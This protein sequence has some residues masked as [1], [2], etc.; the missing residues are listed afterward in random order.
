VSLNEAPFSRTALCACA[1]RCEARKRA[2]YRGAASYATRRQGADA[3]A[4][5]GHPWP[6]GGRLFR[7]HP[8]CAAGNA[9][10]AAAWAD[11]CLDGHPGLSGPQLGCG[12]CLPLRPT[13]CSC[14]SGSARV[15][16]AAACRAAARSETVRAHACTPV[17]VPRVAPPT[18]VVCIGT[19]R[20][21][22]GRTNRDRRAD[23]AHPW[24]AHTRH[25]RQ[26]EAC[27][28]TRAPARVRA[29][30]GRTPP[31]QPGGSTRNVNERAVSAPVVR[32]PTLR[33]IGLSRI[34]PGGPRHALSAP[35]GNG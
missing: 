15:R 27:R 19:V 29:G 26:R 11:P 24:C 33:K 35:A 10:L 6:L 16:P 9:A 25:S 2:A 3:V 1:G 21:P 18:R 23:R 30:G 5:G 17:L 20:A 13:L 31:A 34:D 7:A 22:R 14:T 8:K 32:A 12:P 28:N 4:R